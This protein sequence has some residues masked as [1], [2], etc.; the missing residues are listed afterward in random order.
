MPL[1]IKACIRISTV[2]IIRVP[3]I[4]EKSGHLKIPSGKIRE[5]SIQHA[6]ALYPVMEQY[7]GFVD[8]ESVAVR[9]GMETT[10]KDKN[11]VF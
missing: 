1:Y 2:C 8:V 7:M 6:T 11:H 5:K 3:T 4:R 10:C 9:D